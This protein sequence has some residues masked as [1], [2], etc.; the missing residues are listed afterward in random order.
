M[1]TKNDILVHWLVI[2]VIT[3]RMYFYIYR[4]P[5]CNKN[6][7][8]QKK[9]ALC[10]L[11]LAE[12]TAQAAASSEIMAPIY[13]TTWLHIPTILLSVL[14]VLR[15]NNFLIRRHVAAQHNYMR[16]TFYGWSVAVM[17]VIVPSTDSIQ[18][19]RKLCSFSFVHK[20]NV[21]FSLFYHKSG[22]KAVHS[23]FPNR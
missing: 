7:I 2:I 21:T 20:K 6:W 23:S 17:R 5:T 3:C 13:R 19:L 11:L 12:F 22:S 16:Y 15:L 10:Y 1:L 18:N 4:T 9:F 8:K 14:V